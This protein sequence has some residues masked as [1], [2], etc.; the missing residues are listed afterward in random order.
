MSIVNMIKNIDTLERSCGFP[1]GSINKIKYILENRNIN[2]I[3]VDKKHNYEELEK[4]NYKK[5]NK[6]NELLLESKNYIDKLVR[7]NKIK[8]Y[9]IKDK[10]CISNLIKKLIDIQDKIVIHIFTSIL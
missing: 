8:E 3:I 6:Y 9:L 1:L 5:K 10:F 7:I 2:Y 4:V